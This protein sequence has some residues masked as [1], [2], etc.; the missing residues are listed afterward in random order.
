[1][2]IPPRK[3]RPHDQ[4]GRRSRIGQPPGHHTGRDAVRNEEFQRRCVAA[5]L[6]PPPPAW[7]G[8]IAEG[9]ETRLAR[10]ERRR[11]AHNADRSAETVPSPF[12]PRPRSRLPGP[13]DSSAGSSPSTVSVIPPR[14]RPQAVPEA[15]PPNPSGSAHSIFLRKGATDFMRPGPHPGLRSRFGGVWR[16]HG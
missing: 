11:P 15:N 3:E 4:S 13:I 16:K 10:L 6:E 9:G 2:I 14:R 12:P 1:M 7:P 8:F 5:P